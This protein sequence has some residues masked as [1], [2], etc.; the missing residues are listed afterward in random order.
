M[1]QLNFARTIII[2]KTYTC[3]SIFMHDHC[4]Q[5]IGSN[6]FLEREKTL[7]SCS[8]KTEPHIETNVG[9]D[10]VGVPLVKRESTEDGEVGMG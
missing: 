10:W 2:K 6:Q 8:K 5:S 3:Q 1:M 7:I 4:Q 9:D